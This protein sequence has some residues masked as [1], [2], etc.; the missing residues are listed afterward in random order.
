MLNKSLSEG[1][2]TVTD[3]RSLLKNDWRALIRSLPTETMREAETLFYFIE[4]FVE[5][6]DEGFVD[7]APDEELKEKILCLLSKLN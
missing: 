3:A 5:D 2:F 4:G 6:V 7:D 1:K